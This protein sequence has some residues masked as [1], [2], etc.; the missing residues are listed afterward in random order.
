MLEFSPIEVSD[1]K[2]VNSIF[3]KHTISNAEH[4][5][6]TM[7]EWSFLHPVCV[8]VVEDTVFMRTHEKDS[9][10]DWYLAPTGSM[11]FIKAVELC[12]QDSKKRGF[13]VKFY[14]LSKEQEEKLKSHYKDKFN[15]Y[16][17]RD[18]ADYIYL[19]D[20]L[21]KLEGKKYQKKRNHIS[22]FKRDN[23]VYEYV[24]MT[25]D[26]AQEAIDF[27]DEWFLSYGE[28]DNYN[29]LKEKEAIHS[30]LNNFEELELFGAMIKIDNKVIAMTIASAINDE[31][32]DIIVEK[33]IHEINGA[34][35][36]I[37]QEF[38]LNCLK[39]FKYINREDDLGEEN[40]RKAK[41][42]YFPIEINEKINAEYLGD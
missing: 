27:E 19:A 13:E 34:Y 31:M 6:A 25:K 12:I 7:Y 4:C 11:D 3:R 1:F 14:S 35:A 22:R 33:A 8:C 28:A 29:L 40:L 26:N 36:I 16:Y 38:A 32:V 41:L 9:L 23:P 24:P 20:D 15:I 5:F 17:D 2:K 21:R 30:M 37:N 18:T 39:N 42:S 10:I